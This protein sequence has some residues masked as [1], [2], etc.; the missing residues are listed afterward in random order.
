[1]RIIL[2]DLMAIKVSC[3]NSKCLFF[4]LSI[5]LAMN[6]QFRLIP[7]YDNCNRVV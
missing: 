4:S 6:I 2:C 5:T 3:I 1:M 7:L